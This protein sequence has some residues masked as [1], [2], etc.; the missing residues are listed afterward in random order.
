MEHEDLRL[1]HIYHLL[2]FQLCMCVH[3]LRY[4]VSVPFKNA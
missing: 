1:V 3:Y 2:L 4:A